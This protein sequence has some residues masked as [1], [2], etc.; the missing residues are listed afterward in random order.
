MLW[1]FLTYSYFLGL[2]TLTVIQNAFKE[3]NKNH[4][5][6]MDISY[7][8]KKVFEL[9]S[10]GKTEGVFQLES[11]GMK[12]FMKELK[13]QNIEDII[14]GISLYRPGPMDFIP[15]YIRGKNNVNSVKYLHPALEHILKPTYGCI[16]Y[17]EQVMQIVRDLAGYSLG[18]SD[19]VR[20]A[21]SK[22]K[23]DVMALERKNFIYGL[24]EDVP[25]CLK[26]GIS[27]NVANKIFDDMTDFAKYAFNKSHAAAYAVVAYQTAW[28][29]TYYPV[30]FMAALLTSVMD[31]KIKVSEYIY[32]CK[33]MN[34]ELLPPDINEGYSNFSVSNGKIRFGLSAIKNVGKGNIKAIVESR[35]KNG[36]FKS[37]SQF[38]ELMSSS[39][40]TRCIESLIK[41]GAFDS[42]GGFRSQYMNVYKEIYTSVGN[43][44]R[45]NI[46]GQISLFESFESE[47]LNSTKDILPNIPEYEVNK[48]LALEKEVLGIYVSGHPLSKYNPVLSQHISSTSLNFISSE[49]EDVDYQSKIIDGQQVIVGGII[50]SVSIKYTKNNQVMAFLTLEDTFGDMEII[51]FP[52]VYKSFST[53]LNEDRVVLI[54]GRASISEDQQ[55]KI[56]SE[57]IID[58]DELIQ[59]NKVLWLKVE[60]NNPNIFEQ[61]KQILLS[62]KGKVK[63]K[64]YVQSNKQTLALNQEYWINPSKDLLDRLKVFLDEKSV[65]LKEG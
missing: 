25:G 23:E 3:I 20:R 19:M 30:E 8:D 56:I 47:E 24:G 37:L 27:E 44:K 36:L 9:I 59:M 6:V 17:Q 28:L 54:S 13:P 62:S 55:P 63:V 64:T 35:N 32:A 48:K 10:S 7:D 41:A 61:L 39:L 22:K 14:A 12:Q 57:R 16:V 49:D 21:M 40:N 60:D 52:N 43:N 33:K 50:S 34:I 51:V 46:Q 53:I 38:L 45:K 18:R 5:K 65:I 26:N 29:K 58:Y 2:R 1:L 15:Q 11:A 4:H 31:N 42:L